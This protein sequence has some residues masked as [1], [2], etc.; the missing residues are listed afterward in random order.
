M[1]AWLHTERWASRTPQMR[2]DTRH[3]L[4]GQ[5]SVSLPAR[6]E[7]EMTVLVA[8]FSCFFFG[9]SSAHLPGDSLHP[10]LEHNHNSTCLHC[11]L[12]EPVLTLVAVLSTKGWRLQTRGRWGMQGRV[13]RVGV[14]LQWGWSRGSKS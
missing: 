12:H 8:T 4:G 11:R 5:L 9:L 3:S 14:G 10:T 6:S 2:P 1:P 13:P 7:A